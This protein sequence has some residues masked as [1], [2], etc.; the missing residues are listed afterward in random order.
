MPAGVIDRA[1]LARRLAVTSLLVVLVSACATTPPPRTGAKLF[2]VA[3]Q[4]VWGS[5]AAQLGGAYTTVVSIVDSPAVD[6]HDYE[7]TTADARAVATSA[8]TIVN[9]AGYDPWATR[10]V[11]ANPSDRRVVLDVG[12]LVGVAAGG[13]PHRWYSPDDVRQVIDAITADYTRLDPP[14]ASGYAQL[15]DELVNTA[16]KPYFDLV[17]EVRQRFAG[18]PVGASESIVVPLAQALG[19]DLLTPPS[20][21]DAISEGADPTAGDKAAIDR[22]ISGG[23]I[24]VYVYNGQNATPDVQRQVDAARANGIGVVTVTETLTPRGATFQAWQVGQLA[25]LRQAL[26]AATGQ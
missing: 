17:A 11:E 24:K 5:L 15:H 19:L 21:L 14:H 4:N 26:A 2:V 8:M 25:A 16:M 13:N 1:R 7:P 12:A 3:A 10:L 9:G 18:T 23:Q 20:F 22:Q 6:P